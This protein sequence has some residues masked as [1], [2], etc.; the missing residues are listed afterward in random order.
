M[1]DYKLEKSDDI[2]KCFKNL[3][4]IV[5]FLRDPVNGC[6]WD[7]EQMP[8][9]IIR[10]MQGEIYEYID[11]L[12][13]NDNSEI[14]EELGDIFLNLFLLTKIH[15]Q[16][17]D[18]KATDSI[19]DACDK[20]IRR[21]PHV[22]SNVEVNNSDEVIK[23][24]QDI[25]KNVEGRKESKDDF[26]DK[27]ERNAPE[28]ERCYKI[29]KKAAKVGFD[30]PDV[31]GVYDKLYEEINEVKDA[32]NPENITEEL[33]DVLFVAVN[34]CRAYKV[35]PQDALQK[36]NAKFVNRFNEVYRLA[37]EKNQKLEDL[38]P[39]EWNDLWIQ[40]KKLFPH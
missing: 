34:L 5:N 13:D 1:V 27:V 33:G 17:G 18:F 29:S 14:S 15:D 11:A 4:E 30:W 20:Y 19:N 21:H 37:N 26:F 36:A 28:L 9:D 8:K 2:Y 24:W 38:S 32:K 22:F 3:Y 6:P 31:D 12:T 39:E 16:N 10:S 7:N 40:S 35:K 23:N 25:K